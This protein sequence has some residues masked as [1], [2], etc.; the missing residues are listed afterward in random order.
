M[1]EK[2][3]GSE[4]FLLLLILFILIILIIIYIYILFR[5]IVRA[6]HFD[7]GNEVPY[8]KFDKRLI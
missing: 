4:S 6:R 5:Y 7:Q 8:L 3:T 1:Y 2:T